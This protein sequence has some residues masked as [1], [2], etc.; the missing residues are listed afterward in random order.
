MYLSR[1]SAWRPEEVLSNQDLARMVDTSDE[2]IFDHVGI[3]ERRK[4][5]KDLP[6][7]EQGAR[8]ARAGGLSHPAGA[9]E[10]PGRV[11]GEM[12]TDMD[13]PSSG[14]VVRARLET[15][16]RRRAGEDAGSRLN[17]KAV[18]HARLAA[19]YGSRVADRGEHRAYL[20]PGSTAGGE[21]GH[22]E[23]L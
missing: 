5:P 3:R 9:G 4:S 7:H 17:Q 15:A 8:A 2:W 23:S 11:D 16:R 6:V 18:M 22:A 21:S 12:D 13:S 10:A 14:V 20:K 19:L 1:L